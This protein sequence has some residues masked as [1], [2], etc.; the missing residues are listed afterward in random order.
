MEDPYK[1]KMREFTY[2]AEYDLGHIY[3]R[4]RKE[5]KIVHLCETCFKGLSR[6]AEGGK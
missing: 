1:A 6:I 5:K 2:V 3:P 4:P